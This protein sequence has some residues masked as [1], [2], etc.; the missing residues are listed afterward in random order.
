MSAAAYP[1][2]HARAQVLRG[3]A[4]TAGPGWDGQEISADD[5]LTEDLGLESLDAILLVLELEDK[6]GIDVE[7]HELAS[8]A[9][10]GDLLELVESK[11][12]AAESGSP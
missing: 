6:L 4:A 10:V 7:D 5:S 2:D 9:T 3:L 11:C 1:G 12:Q 8:L